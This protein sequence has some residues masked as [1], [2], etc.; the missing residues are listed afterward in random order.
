MTNQ[1]AT[2]PP[3]PFAEAVAQATP[4]GALI[5]LP[6]VQKYV[7]LSRT[8]IYRMA[9]EGR[10]PKP[11]KGLG[12]RASFWKLSEVLAYIEALSPEQAEG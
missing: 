11:V 3:N 6:E 9:A 8:S 4:A 1:A 2:Q 5:K 10:F 7:P 12:G